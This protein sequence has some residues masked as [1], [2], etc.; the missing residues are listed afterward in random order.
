MDT[1]LIF[2]KDLENDLEKLLSEE[3]QVDNELKEY[4]SS[5]SLHHSSSKSLSNKR[6]SLDSIDFNNN[7]K[8]IESFGPFLEVVTEDSKKL[9]SQIDD[10]RQLSDRLS[11]MVRRLDLIQM[12]A[13]QALTCV[14][15]V[16]NLKDCKMKLLS[17]I[18]EQNL[19]AAVSYIRQ[20][21]T[22]DAEALKTSD[23]YNTIQRAETETRDLV[24][25]AFNQAINDS[26]INAVMALCPLL[27]T[28][29]L[30]NEARDSFLVF[31][32][33]KVFIAVSA[34]AATVVD[35]TVDVATGYAQALSNIFNAT[36]LILQKYLPL[37]IQ[38]MENSNGDLAF[39]RKLH[40]K[41]E[42][43][44]GI[45]L[46]R[47]MKYRNIRQVISQIKSANSSNSIPK[48]SPS[49]IH[50]ILDELGLLIQ[51]CCMYAKYLKTLCHDAE[52]RTRNQIKSGGHD[53]I[54]T[55][56]Q[57]PTEFDKM[58][59]E[60][61]NKYYFEGESF[62][63]H[64]ATKATLP[65]NIDDKLEK[66]I[67][68]DECFYVLQRCGIRA[69]STNNIQAACAIL[70]LTSDLLMLDVV[71]QATNYV[72]QATSKIG[73]VL[74]EYLNKYTKSSSN[75]SSDTTLSIGLKSAM[76]L[77]SSI[78]G[79]SS[80][81]SIDNHREY[82]L[83][84]ID[85]VNNDDP[86]RVNAYADV[87]NLMERCIRYTDRLNRDISQA[88][89]SVFGKSSESEQDES[90]TQHLPKKLTGNFPSSTVSTLSGEMDKI[91]LCREDFEAAKR[92][93]DQVLHQGL[94]Q[95]VDHANTC[96]KAILNFTFSKHG[97]LG[98]IRLDLTD[99]R[100][101]E[102]L[103]ISLLP[104]S[105]VLPFETLL[106]ILVSGLSDTNR[107]SLIVLLSEACCLRLEDFIHH[108][109]RFYF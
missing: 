21:H 66:V 5:L 107:D 8:K 28:L 17:A 89:E 60:L 34:D 104:K 13:K 6:I 41:C 15:D 80:S 85:S 72:K 38:G 77:A 32:E 47:F 25:H 27:Q 45:I 14:E 35:N 73:D 30:E 23:D 67:G 83:N 78:T 24:R 31:M 97:P 99:D 4:F 33:S 86:W 40:T 18:D 100:F 11:M 75:E 26:D 36:Y 96:M 44:S 57:G 55:V 98:G 76:S 20:V 91:K 109:S 95:L 12:R 79:A 2:R 42:N 39:I 3:I 63:L 52:T 108:V 90:T 81:T 58:I 51:Y 82:D 50:V 1:S 106:N 94:N 37:V 84:N 56:F 102:Q 16:I 92:A 46:K 68:L 101:D 59:D 49:D 74:S 105:L 69:I 54:N 70:H 87:L 64:Q 62:I 65:K 7:I 19:P 10:C 53:V 48:V 103:A 9:A 88:A 22:I 71:Q 93:F 29:G 43:E 61:I